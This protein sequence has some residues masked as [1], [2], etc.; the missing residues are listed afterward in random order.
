VTP[1][2]IAAV[3]AIVKENR[4]VIV[5]EI[6]AHLDMSLGLAYHTVHDTLQFHKVSAKWVPRQLTA[7]LTTACWS[8]PGTFEML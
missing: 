2:F 1:Q 7:E 8:L 6:V 4:C 5:N 3:D